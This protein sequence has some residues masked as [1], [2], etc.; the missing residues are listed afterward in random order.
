MV[1]KLKLQHIR[2][3]SLT[4]QMQLPFVIGHQNASLIHLN[5]QS[6][7]GYRQLMGGICKSRNS[8]MMESQIVAFPPHLEPNPQHLFHLGLL[9]SHNYHQLSVL[10]TLNTH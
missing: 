8:Q 5:Q 9:I 6:N 2:P 3:F 1:E 7:F 10:S 4:G